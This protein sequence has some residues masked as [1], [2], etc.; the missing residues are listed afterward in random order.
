MLILLALL[1]VNQHPQPVDETCYLFR[2][3]RIKADDT[4]ER[5]IDGLFHFS[6]DSFTQRP[7][8]LQ[9]K[10]NIECSSTLVGVFPSYLVNVIA[11][12]R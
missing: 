6:R 11:I 3:S 9:E 8:D 5:K 4:G 12:R 1:A 10:K 7:T 2:A